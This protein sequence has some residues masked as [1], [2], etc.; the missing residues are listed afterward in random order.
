MHTSRGLEPLRSREPALCDGQRRTLGLALRL[1]RNMPNLLV[2]GIVDPQFHLLS[3]RGKIVV[4]DR[5][6]GRVLR[7]G[8]FGWQWRTRKP[9]VVDTDGRLRLVQEGQ[10]A[11]RMFRRLAQRS[12]VVQYPERSS[13]RRNHEVVAVNGQVTH[14]GR[15]KIQLQGLPLTAV[16]KGDIDA[17]LGPR[18][19][20]PFL[21][22]ILAHCVDKVRR[23]E[24]SRDRLPALA[25]IS[26]AVNVGRLVVHAMALHRRIGHGGVEV[27]WLDQRNPAPTLVRCLHPCR[28]HI[29]PRPSP[30]ACKRDDS[31]VAPRPHHVLVQVR[32]CDR[33]KDAVATLNRVLDTWTVRLAGVVDRVVGGSCCRARHDASRR[34]SSRLRPRKIRTDL[35]PVQPAVRSLHHEL[36]PEIE[37]ILIDGRKDQWRC[38]RVAVLPRGDLTSK[39]RHRPGCDVPRQRASFIP[40]RHRPIASADIEDIRVFGID[41]KVPALAPTGRK[42]VARRDQL[43]VGAAHDGRAAAVLLCP[44]DG[45]GKL[46]VGGYVIHLGSR[47][48]VPG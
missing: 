32:R 37:S 11:R 1:G 40:P 35:L 13:M 4:E 6:I 39:D 2:V 10:A 23:F 24:A 19:E 25:V 15:G 5:S 36:C 3:V 20:Q 9:I 17:K 12:D 47:L 29:R 8:L 30:V 14:R 18:I 22:G 34:S 16:V 41:G 33:C 44:I 38:P 21:L 27:R 7:S 28:S 31:R 48:V 45:V 42:P 46:I 43:M 26:R